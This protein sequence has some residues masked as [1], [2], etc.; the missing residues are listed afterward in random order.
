[1]SSEADTAK[2]VLVSGCFDLLHSG[3]VAFFRAAAQHG[4]LYV[5]L[6]S[7][8]NIKALK[9][10]DVMY[11]DAERQFMVSNI[12]CVHDAK[13]S[14][15]TG[16]YDFEADMALIKPDIYFVN[17]DASKLEGRVDICERLWIEM[18]IAPRD[19]EAGLKVRSSTSIKAD[20]AKGKATEAAAAQAEFERAAQACLEEGVKPFDHTIPW[21]FCF[22]GGWLDLD[23]VNKYAKGC[24]V[25]INIKFNAKICKD[26][27]GLATSSRKHC[28]KAWNGKIPSN[29]GAVQAAKYMW[30]IENFSRFS[31][32]RRSYAAGSQ[33]HLGLMFPGINKLNYGEP[34]SQF[35][36][37]SITLN[38]LDDPAQAAIFAW[39]EKVLHVVEIPFVSRPSDFDSQR[40]NLLKDP[41]VSEERKGEMAQAIADAS[42]AAWNAIITMDTAGLGQVNKMF[43]FDYD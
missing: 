7:A 42:E 25:T 28:I 12:A 21:R 20:L 15:G 11:G 36:S 5:R 41:T 17:D 9:D 29:L 16:V 4:D 38:D 31:T 23:W 8:A 24:V 1:M 6:G 34:P 33:D 18:V 2:K 22:C 13:I 26:R 39:L 14:A 32:G 37:S 30:G 27:C 40:I 35:A 10:H 19:P 43:S 3:H